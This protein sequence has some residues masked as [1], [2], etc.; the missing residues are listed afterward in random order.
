MRWIRILL[1]VLAVIVVVIG[2]VVVFVAT[3]DLN[4][5][6]DRIAGLVERFTGRELV[7]DGRVDLEFFEI[8]RRHAVRP[9]LRPGGL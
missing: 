1:I 2:G 6:K 5:H 8:D 4:D 3:L 9:G 7:L